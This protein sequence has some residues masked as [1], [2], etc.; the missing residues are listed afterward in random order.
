[1]GTGALFGAAAGSW[2][3]ILGTIVGGLIGG[4]LSVF[5]ASKGYDKF[6]EYKYDYNEEEEKRDPK[7][8]EAIRLKYYQ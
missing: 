2:I 4:C 7:L 3:P 5:L 8:R 6:V 1:M